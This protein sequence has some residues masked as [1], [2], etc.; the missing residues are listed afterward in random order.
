MDNNLD[1][2]YSIERENNEILLILILFINLFILLC[3]C[4]PW[5]ILTGFTMGLSIVTI[6]Y[7]HYYDW[8]NFSMIYNCLHCIN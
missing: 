2:E 4:Y 1:L 8:C 5:Y 3:I 7:W 6:I